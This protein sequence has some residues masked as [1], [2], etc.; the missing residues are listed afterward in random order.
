MFE[1]GNFSVNKSEV[2]FS[3][4]SADHA[5]EQENRVVK[6]TWGIK[7]IGNNENVLSDYFL[8]AAEMGN[9][10]ESFCTNFDLDDKEARKREEHYQLTGT[11]NTRLTENVKK[12]VEVFDTYE[13]NFETCGEVFNILTKKVLPENIAQNFFPVKEIGEQKY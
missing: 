6:V 9:I 11:K 12:I 4:I 8:T 2:P 5:L 13:S 10:V 1:S 7:G 3:A